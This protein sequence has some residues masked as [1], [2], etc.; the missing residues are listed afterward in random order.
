MFNIGN[1]IVPPVGFTESCE[2]YKDYKI[3]VFDKVS[4]AVI[5]DFA[6]WI[7]IKQYPEIT[8]SEH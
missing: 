7:E 6:N 1:S 3:E 4:G 2:F 8:V 5:T